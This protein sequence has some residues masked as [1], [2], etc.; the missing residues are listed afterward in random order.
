MPWESLIPDGYLSGFDILNLNGPN[1]LLLK[2]L[3]LVP[4]CALLALILNAAGLATTVIRR[5]AGTVPLIIIVYAVS[6]HGNSVWHFILWGNWIA[7]ISGVLIIII[8]DPSKSQRTPKTLNSLQLEKGK[9]LRH[10][11][12][13]ISDF[14]TSTADFYASIEA[15]LKAR[16]VPGLE[17]SRVDFA[18]GGLISDKR[19]YLRMIRERFVF[20]ICSAPFGTAHFFSCRF[21][22]IPTIIRLWQLALVFVGILGF[23]AVFLK[24]FGF[25]LGTVVVVFTFAATVYLLRNAIAVGLRDVDAA[26]VKSPLVGSIYE[27]FFRN[28]T[29]YREDTRLMYCD[30]VNKVVEARIE[31]TTGARGLKLIQINDYDPIMRELYKPRLMTLTANEAVEAA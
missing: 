19:E 23:I 2:L 24:L 9:V 25:L 5:V 29:Y 15:E 10:W 8:P 1:R 12:V 30:L 31:E 6:N 21:A 28:E 18:E 13:L 7:L 14:Q 26:L 17:I 3:W 27:R 22:E 16:K 20:D 4:I 11:Y